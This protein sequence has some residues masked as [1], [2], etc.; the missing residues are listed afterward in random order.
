MFWTSLLPFL[1][2]TTTKNGLNDRQQRD[3]DGYGEDG[4][5][6]SDV[7]WDR[8]TIPMKGGIPAVCGGTEEG[9][10]E[11]MWGGY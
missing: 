3:E 9:R 7:C 1:S 4:C 10:G 6:S 5:Y 2:A 11:R 8:K